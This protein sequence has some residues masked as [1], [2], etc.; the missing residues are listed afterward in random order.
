MKKLITLQEAY[1]LIEKAYAVIIDDNGLCYPSVDNLTG[2]PANEWLYCSWDDSDF[3]EYDVRFI[4]EEQEIFFD[5][6]NIYMKDSEDEDTK[7]TL[8]VKMG[9]V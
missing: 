6:T 5:G 8:L 7:I 3:N 2:D 1:N 4:E 9:T